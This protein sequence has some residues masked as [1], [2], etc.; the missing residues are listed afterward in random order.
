MVATGEFFLSLVRNAEGKPLCGRMTYL[1]AGH[2]YD[3]YAANSDESLT[4]GAV[5][6]NQ[7]QLL[8]YLKAIGATDFDYGRIPPG[9]DTMD[10]IYVAK[11][12]SGGHPVLYNGEWEYNKSNAI[13]WF[14]SMYRYCLH[15]AK[16]Y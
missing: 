16:R 11:S 1:R 8:E 5:Y 13:N 3:V 7:Q 9:R 12:Y 2:A 4:T 10:N 14:Y 15:K 6:Q